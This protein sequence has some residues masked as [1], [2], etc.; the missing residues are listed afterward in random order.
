MQYYKVMEDKARDKSRGQ[1]MKSR[2][3]NKTQKILNKVHDLI[4]FVLLDTWHQHRDGL[5]R[6]E[7]RDRV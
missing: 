2:I 7:N 6:V 3:W 1:V 5:K 4:R